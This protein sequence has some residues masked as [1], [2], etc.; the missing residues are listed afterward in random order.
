MKYL[1]L[2][3]VLFGLPLRARAESG[4]AVAAPVA[5]S[6]GSVVNQAVQVTPSINF[7][8]NMGRGVVCQGTSLTTSLFGLGGLAA[9][10]SE[11]RTD[12][13]ITVQISTPL[14][15]EAVRLCKERARVEIARQVA[16]KDKAELDYHLVRSIKCGEM[17]RNG[18]FYHPSS[19]YASVCLDVIAVAP[20]GSYRNG[21]GTV[22][23][24][25]QTVD[26]PSPSS[27]ST[28]SKPSLSEASKSLSTDQTEA[29]QTQQPQ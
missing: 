10:E 5:S 20:D 24:A 2:F 16:E 6:S 26:T 9:P 11:V 8:Q 18:T 12:Y 27:P 14:D 3:L 25:A 1:L 13:G 23:Q 17:I 19:P 29:S 22:I 28:S 21:V 7:T 15:R 4:N